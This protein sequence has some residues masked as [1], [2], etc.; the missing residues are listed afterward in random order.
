MEWGM[1][2]LIGALLLGAGVID[3]LRSRKIHNKLIL[4][5]GGLSLVSVYAL[6][7][8]RD[9]LHTTLQT[10]IAPW[11]AF[12]LAFIL[13]LPLFGLKVWGG[14]DAKLFLAVSPLLIWPEIP[15]F[16]LTSLAWGA[17]LGL[18]RILLSGRMMQMFANLSQL[19]LHRQPVNEQHLTKVPFSVALFFG[20]LS[21]AT[22]RFYAAVL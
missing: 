8:D 19:I 20:F 3:D 9:I 18:I 7:H 22:L 16:L 5:I 10:L 2:D 21:V 11:L 14:G 4:I 1:L 13:T 12:G 6:P 15:I 17:V